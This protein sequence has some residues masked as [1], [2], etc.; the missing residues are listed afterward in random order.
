MSLRHPP[1]KPHAPSIVSLI[2]A[3]FTARLESSPTANRFCDSSKVGHRKTLLCS[4]VFIRN[5]RRSGGPI[6]FRV[7]VAAL[8]GFGKPLTLSLSLTRSVSRSLWG[9][10]KSVSVESSTWGRP[11]PHCYRFNFSLD[12][13]FRHHLRRQQFCHQRSVMCCNPDLELDRFFGGAAVHMPRGLHPKA[14]NPTTLNRT[15]RK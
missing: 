2:H 14:R 13:L 9:A 11:G 4:F 1:G 5:L 12:P 10:R 15:P 3:V 6:D 8:P 7:A